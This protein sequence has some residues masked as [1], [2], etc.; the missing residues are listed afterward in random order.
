MTSML[1]LLFTLALPWAAYFLQLHLTKAMP[2]VTIMLL[3]HV[4]RTLTGITLQMLLLG[5]DAEHLREA[6]GCYIGCQLRLAFH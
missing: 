3:V 1:L 5:I 6:S 2:R 4:F